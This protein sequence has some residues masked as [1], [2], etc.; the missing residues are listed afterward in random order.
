MKKEQI[1]GI[2]R[3]VIT[4]VGGIMVMKGYIDSETF[5][6]MSGALITLVGGIWS[7]LEKK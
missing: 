6:Q 1:L 2:I 3:H 4:F 5:T 7:V